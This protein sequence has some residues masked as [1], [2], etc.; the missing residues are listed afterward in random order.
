[1]AVRDRFGLPLEAEFCLELG[2]ASL[3]LEVVPSEG[4]ECVA[5]VAVHSVES[6]ELF[7][8]SFIHVRNIAHMVWFVK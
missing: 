5:G 7:A 8:C 2:D 3:E 6:G 4:F 1:M